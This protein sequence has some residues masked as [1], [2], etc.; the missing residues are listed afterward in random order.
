MFEMVGAPGLQGWE[1]GRGGVRVRLLVRMEAQ[2]IECA[3]R[4][5][6]AGRNAMQLPPG[7]QCQP[8]CLGWLSSL[9]SRSSP[10][11][12]TPE[13]GA[14]RALAADKALQP[15]LLW[16]WTWKLYWVPFTYFPKVNLRCGWQGWVGRCIAVEQNRRGSRQACMRD[17]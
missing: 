17:Q 9:P 7:L 15:A 8:S 2:S 14:T 16:A 11:A 5:H 10:V 4:R 3:S 12:H 13:A 6:A 1:A